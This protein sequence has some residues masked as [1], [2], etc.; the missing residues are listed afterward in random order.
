MKY[1]NDTLDIYGYSIIKIF[2]VSGLYSFLLMSCLFLLLLLGM[3]GMDFEIKVIIRTGCFL[4]FL[5]IGIAYGRP[6]CCLFDVWKQEEML[7]L[8]WKERKDFT[9]PIAQREWYATLNWKNFCL[10]H[11]RYVKQILTLDK[12]EMEYPLKNQDTHNITQYVLFYETI[13]GQRKKIIFFHYR[14]ALRFQD[15]YEHH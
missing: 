13:E 4:F 8:Y 10:L 2:L 15:W 5:A 9:K 3:V 12:Q 11:R 1:D 14:E 7:Q 6:V